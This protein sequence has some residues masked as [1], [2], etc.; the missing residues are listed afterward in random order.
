MIGA[1][2]AALVGVVFLVAGAT[3]IAGR[4]LWPVQ[5]AALGAPRWV[6]P[7]VPVW[8]IVVGA[9]CVVQIGAPWP[10]I[11]AGATLLAFTALLVRVLRRGE[12]PPCACFGA[13]AARPL[14]WWHVVRN[15]VFLLLAATAVVAG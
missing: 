5:A 3:K 13:V 9:L 8:E 11:A 6:T 10:A 14:S 4:Q 1:A 15:G 2:A 7:L 12:H